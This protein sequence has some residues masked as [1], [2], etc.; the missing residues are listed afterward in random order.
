ML[1]SVA[2]RLSG[3]SSGEIVALVGKNI[4]HLVQ[5]LGPGAAL[6]RRQDEAFDRRWGTETSRLANLSTLNVD[7][8]R[9][10]HG[11]RYQPS[12]GEALAHAVKTLGIAP[13][14][15]SLVDYGSGKGRIVLMAAA[16]GFRRVIG[17][18][19][20]P[21]LCAVAEENVRRFMA[22]GGAKQAPEIV[23]GDAGAFA[24]PAG[25]LLAYLYNPVASPV[26]D[27]VIARLEA[28]ADGGAPVAVAYVDPQHLTS[29]EQ[30]G[31]W[32]VD[33]Q[34]SDLAVLR[35]S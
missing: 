27:E 21:E 22:A 12:N 4:A 16:M 35:A 31:R 24:P 17:V 28:H 15:W 3:R 26:L 23:L 2:Q 20:S 33:Q 32:R 7:A 9:A 25:P 6:R 5:S 1:R 13:G 14:D 18:E 11:V 34:D 19:F 29:F 10:R 8:S 30:R